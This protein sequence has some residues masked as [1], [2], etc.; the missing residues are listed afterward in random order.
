VF[1]EKERLCTRN[2]NFHRNKQIA[3]RPSAMHAADPDGTKIVPALRDDA[4]FNFPARADK[5]NPAPRCQ[6][7]D[8]IG[9]REGRVE[10]STRPAASK[11]NVW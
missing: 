10:M 11:Q 2:G 1:Y 3:E 8:L 4:G 6:R 7:L 5:E 9:N